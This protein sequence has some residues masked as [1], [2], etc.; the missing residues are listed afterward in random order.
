[1]IIGSGLGGL[2]T[3]AFLAKK[4]YEVTILEKHFQFGGYATMFKRKTSDN[5]LINYDVSLHG[6]GNLTKGRDF[7]SRYDEIGLFDKIK[8]LRKSE[9]ATIVKDDVEI[10]IPDSIDK[11][12]DESIIRYPDDEKGIKAFFDFL[13]DFDYDMEINT[14]RNKK[15]PKYYNSLSEIS[16]YDLVKKYVDNEDFIRDFCFLWLYY[17]L[18]PK[19][20]NALYYLLAWIGYHVGGTYYVKGGGGSISDALVDIIKSSNGILVKNEEVVQLVEENGLI[21]KAIT[22]KGNEYCADIVILNACPIPLLKT[23]NDS[24]LKQEEMDKFKI[25]SPSISLTQLYVGVDDAPQKYGL[26]KADYFFEVKD[27]DF[28]FEAIKVRDYY[29]TPMGI[30]NYNILDPKLNEDCGFIAITIGDYL[31]LWPKEKEEYKNKKEVV[32]QILCDR[33]YEKFPNIKGHITSLELGTPYTMKRYT[34]NIDGAV[35]GLEQSIKCAGFS[36]PYFKSSFKNLYYASAW[37]QPGGGYE[38]ALRAGII[39]SDLILKENLYNQVEQVENDTLSMPSNVYVKGMIAEANK[40]AAKNIT[41]VYDLYFKDE[42]KHYFINVNRGK[43]NLVSDGKVDVKI[44]CTYQTWKNIGDGII[45]GEDAFRKKDLIVEG[46][47]E[48][49]SS[50]PLIFSS[51][52]KVGEVKVTKKVIPYATLWIFLTLIPWIVFWTLQHYISPLLIA[53]VAFIWIAFLQIFAKP[54]VMRKNMQLENITLLS[55]S[56]YLLWY[57]IDIAT[58]TKYSHFISFL[59]P[60]GLLMYLPI[61]A[62]SGEYSEFAYPDF[63]VKTKLFTIINRNITI[64]WI[65]IFTIQTL[66][67]DV[68]FYNYSWNSIFYLVE[69]IGIVYSILYPKITLGK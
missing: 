27:E 69:V 11:Y 15:I 47:I 64:V 10:D 37:T 17:G 62:M 50:V 45:Q 43:V 59:L 67:V 6:I 40:E 14:Y 23:I 16:I 54:K 5:K 32:T 66:L 20:L 46:D 7:Y 35:Y 24:Q 55:F 39:C 34:N 48:L 51:R 60:L 49:F 33:L 18:Q 68:I 57:S 61:K 58:F 9:T 30:V 28:G 21:K 44:I 36:R 22:K 65:I 26:V 52:K 31:K 12:L 56:I 2:S 41:A 29:N 19:E 25:A 63:M 1:M 53:S 38:G 4:G 42:D 3:G 8:P 13:K